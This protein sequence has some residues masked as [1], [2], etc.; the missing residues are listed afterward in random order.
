MISMQNP[1]VFHIPAH[2]G[3]VLLAAQALKDGDHSGFGGVDE[4]PFGEFGGD[5]QQ[6]FGFS[7]FGIPCLDADSLNKTAFRGIHFHFNGVEAA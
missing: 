7:H 6:L 1:S 5:F 3:F 2:T 4:S